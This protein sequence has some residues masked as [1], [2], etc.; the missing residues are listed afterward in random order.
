MPLEQ[1]YTAQS[2]G[3]SSATAGQ[4]TTKDVGYWSLEKCRKAYNDYLFNKREEIDEQIDARRYYHGAQWTAEQIAVLKKRKQPVMTFNRVSRKINGAIGQIERMRQDPKAYPRTPQHEQGADL[5][6]ACVRYVLDEQQWKAKSPLCGQDGAVDGIGGIELEIGEGDKGDPEIEFDVVDVQ[7]FFY[8]PRSYKMDFSDAR[9]MGIGKWLDDDIAKEMFPDAPDAAFQSDQ[10]LVNNTD[11][12]NRWFRTDG[13]TKRVRIVDIWYQHKG[14][15][16]WAIFSGNS[17]LME[18]K[19]YLRDEKK[20]DQC[21][22]F[23]FSGNVDHDGDRYGFVRNIKSAQDGINAKNSKLQHLLASNR[24]ILSQGAVNDVE[25][26]RAEWARA[27]GVI[28]T[29][30][31]VNEG[32]K[33]DDRSFDFA[34]WT[35]LLEL[36]NAEIEG[37]GPNPELLGETSSAE[38]GRAIA[39]KQQA[40]IAE[41]GPFILAYRGWKI[42]VYRGIWNAV[43][44]HWTGERWI[45]VTDSED[46]MQF[47][48]LNKLEMG[49][50]GPQIV[51]QIGSLDVD[52]IMDEGP[53]SMT[54]MQDT[55]DALMGL[56]QNGAQVPPDVLIE[57]SPGIDSRTKKMLREKM[58]QQQEKPDP[59]TQKLQAQMQMKQQE[60]QMNGQAKQQELQM[61]QQ[62]MEQTAQID[63]AKAAQQIQLEREKA[64][65]Q[66]EIE[67][68][69]AMAQIAI[70]RMEA[71]ANLELQAHQADQDAQV[72][73]FKVEHETNLKRETAQMD[74]ELADQT[75]QR[76]DARQSKRDD[77]EL[78]QQAK[79]DAQ[80]H[81]R[82]KDKIALQAKA[83][84]KAPA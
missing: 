9:F 34:G 45:R 33:T 2:A 30:R 75:A 35:K 8:D 55:Y 82:E 44:Q 61:K 31:P 54:M 23:M 39:L 47:I 32:V 51:N 70:K 28:V 14:G 18:G 68:K 77:A 19:S 58:Q 53:D 42:R 3:S 48:Q 83:K 5:A 27:D 10:E 38:S 4:S 74:F 56:A 80:S 60:L 12:E 13:V 71:Q 50:A 43:Q 17:K 29:N 46:L 21:K 36:N 22:Y 66:I 65:A 63:Q 57:L 1:S 20:K 41:L 78:K 15:W 11:R 79:S 24:I 64:Q 69:K 37:F 62:D 67:E 72:Q 81:E 16:C 7:S 26:T 6:T 84:A 49:P 73:A 52:I 59:E 25:K 76:E 40:G